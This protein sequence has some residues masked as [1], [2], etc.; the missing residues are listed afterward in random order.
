MKYM[1]MHYGQSQIFGKRTRFMAEPDS[2]GNPESDVNIDTAGGGGF[3]DDGVD[4]DFSEAV[5]DLKA[6]LAKAKADYQKL[7]IQNDTNSK[8]AKQLKD[9]LRSKQS[10]EEQEEQDRAEK[11][12]ELEALRREVQVSKYSKRYIGIGMD[13]KT[14]DEIA[15]ITPSMNDDE[16]NAFFD[17]I[18]KHIKA[19]EKTAADNAIQKLLKDRPDINAGGGDSDNDPSMAFAKTF[20]SNRQ[21]TGANADILKNYM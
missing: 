8:Q 4:E 11:L 10:K 3:D 7:K 1:N 12:A 5:D 17:A 13:E 6:Q 15:A 19:I 20:I 18:G 14:S 16:A 2:G 9:Q 21:P